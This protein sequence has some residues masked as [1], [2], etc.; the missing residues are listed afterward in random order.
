MKND[1]SSKSILRV[2]VKRQNVTIVPSN[3][4]WGE[5]SCSQPLTSSPDKSGKA[6]MFLPTEQ[7]ILLD[8]AIRAVEQ[9]RISLEIIDLRDLGFLKRIRMEYSKSIPWIEF[10]GKVL[11]GTPT[12]KEI[13]DFISD[14]LQN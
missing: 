12:T 4:N 5:Y 13:M 3:M 11:E 9:M 8:S 14:T 2:Y 7:Q 1:V 6:R 10:M